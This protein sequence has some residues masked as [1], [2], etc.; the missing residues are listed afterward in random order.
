MGSY[1]PSFTSIITVPLSST[2]T[3]CHWPIG[4]FNATTVSELFLCRWMGDDKTGSIGL[5]YSSNFGRLL[6]R[7]IRPP[8]EAD[9]ALFYRTARSA[10]VRLSI[11]FRDTHMRTSL[12]PTSQNHPLLSIQDRH[13]HDT[14]HIHPW[15]LYTRTHAT[16]CYLCI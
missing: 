15:L 9:R 10:S 2:R 7:P 8:I 6:F 5:S 3:V 16:F 12:N 1:A 14:K 11:T 4:M 13:S